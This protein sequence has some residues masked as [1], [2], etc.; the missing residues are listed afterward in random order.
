M[1]K[2]EKHKMPPDI[3]SALINNKVLDDYKS[4]P[5][6]QQND[7][8]GWITSAKLTATRTKRLEKMIKEL[9]IGGVYMNMKHPPSAKHKKK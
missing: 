3:K 6:Y 5:P 9:E 4:R 7:Y 1:L 8:L 2:R